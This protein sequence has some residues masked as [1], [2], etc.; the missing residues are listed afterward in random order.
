[1]FSLI[2][3]EL[4][5]RRRPGEGLAKA[6]TYNRLAK[7]GTYNHRPPLLRRSTTTNGHGEIPLYAPRLRRGDG[8]SYFPVHT[9]LRFSPKALRPSFA[10]S[11]IASSAIWLS[12]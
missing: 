1:M 5:Q 12:V 9:G 4:S 3:S 7:A 8:E 2:E 11:V 10:S 6:G